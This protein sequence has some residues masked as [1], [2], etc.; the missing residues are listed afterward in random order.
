MTLAEERPRGRQRNPESTVKSVGGVQSLTR[1]L[2]ILDALAETD[3]GL[4]LTLLARRVALPPSTAHRLLT[5]LQRQHFV[6]FEPSSMSWQIGVQ[7]FVVGNAFVRSRDVVAV[8]SPYMYRMMEESG[9][10]A[11]LYVLSGGEAICM[12]QV[13]WHQMIRA[14][15]RPGGRVGLHSTAVG[16]AMLAH[17][18]RQ[19]VVD[20]TAR[21]GLPRATRN[22]IVSFKKLQAD[23]TKIR[24]R[25]FAVDDE[26]CALGLR[27]VA[28]PILDDRGVAHAALSLAAPTA[29]ISNERLAPL[30]SMVG[31]AARSVTV[32]LGGVGNTG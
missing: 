13:Q 19:E 31:A 18:P 10:T 5:T 32:E 25:G 4:T 20:I 23:L 26:E 15:S 14:I 2:S 9:E 21:H 22:T 24:S 28:A 27:C 11:N 3:E 8:A 29:R 16:K 6:R 30:G 12:A 7:A 1:A 17:L